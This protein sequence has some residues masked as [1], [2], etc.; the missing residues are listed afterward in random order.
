MWVTT[1]NET[2]RMGA[3][4][5]CSHELSNLS[6]VQ[7]LLVD[8]G[9]TGDDFAYWVGQILDAEVEV[10]KRSELHSFAII[11]KR[12]I[13]ERTFGW[14]DKYRELWKNAGRKL[15]TYLQM[16]KLAIIR[17]LLRRS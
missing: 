5:M 8:S 6:N 4:E 13:V 10:V 9:Y 16:A 1:A 14:L 7:K 2:D 15:H 11:P 17:L 3:L 12:W